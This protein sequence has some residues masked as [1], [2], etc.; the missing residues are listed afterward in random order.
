[1]RFLLLVM[2]AGALSGAADKASA[3]I[4]AAAEVPAC[5][6]RSDAAQYLRTVLIAMAVEADLV[7]D[8]TTKDATVRI[9]VSRAFM[10]LPFASKKSLIAGIAGSF[11]DGV[12][13]KIAVELVENIDGKVYAT[14][15]LVAGELNVR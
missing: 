10:R 8:C 3:A 4:D 12:D 6:D 11:S 14:F 2:L 5:T 7:T 15:D 13:P 1:M 9:W